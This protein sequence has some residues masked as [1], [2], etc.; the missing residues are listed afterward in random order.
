MELP[1]PPGVPLIVGTA[2]VVLAGD[3]VKVVGSDDVS[4]FVEEEVDAP[5]LFCG[6][7]CVELPGP[8]GVPLI[9]GPLSVVRG[10]GVTNGIGRSDVSEVVEEEVNAP[11]LF[12]EWVRVELPGSPDVPLVVGAA[13]EALAESVVNLVDCEEVDDVV[14]EKILPLLFVGV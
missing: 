11:L 6:L 1:G 12:C 7:G 3:V 8:T 13:S 14:E 2:S 9:I 10:G 4:G 5:L